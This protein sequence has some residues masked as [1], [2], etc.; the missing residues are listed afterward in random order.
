VESPA[1]PREMKARARVNQWMDWFLS[2]FS[3]DYHH[4]C[5]YP[6]VLDYLRLSEPAETERQGWHMPRIA[7]HLAILDAQ[8]DTG[9]PFVCG[10]EMSLADYLGACFVTTGEVIDFDLSPYPNVGRWIADLKTHPAWD[11]VHAGFYGF[12]SATET[13][14]FNRSRGR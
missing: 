10:P 13:R 3:M 2:L 7:K 5:I 12:R 4:G 1:Y 8:L 6:R 11:E 9:G 14:L